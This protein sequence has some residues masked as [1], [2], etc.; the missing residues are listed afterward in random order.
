MIPY[1]AL[2]QAFGYTC[3][4]VRV[5]CDPKVAWERQTHN[6]PG[7]KFDAI[8]TAVEHQRTPKLYRGAPW[9]T[10]EDVGGIPK[11]SYRARS[12]YEIYEPYSGATCVKCCGVIVY[13]YSDGSK[14]GF[15]YCDHEYDSCE[16][17]DGDEAPGEPF[18]GRSR[19]CNCG[20]SKGLRSD[21]ESQCIAA[22]HHRNR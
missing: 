20:V 5:L 2:C 21:H 11:A 9:L 22:Y 8:H 7:D 1:L 3:K 16:C 17:C 14:T 18:A 10:E 19:T 4:I 12:S 6:V 15:R 13:S